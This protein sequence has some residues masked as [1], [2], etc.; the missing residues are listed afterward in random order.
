MCGVVRLSTGTPPKSKEFEASTRFGKPAVPVAEIVF[1][2]VSCPLVGSPVSFGTVSSVSMMSEP[3][4][5]PAKLPV[6]ANLTR[7]TAE[8]PGASVAAVGGS[9]VML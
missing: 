5:R 9:G 6:G 1:V 3:V 4:R 7:K 8:C 2:A